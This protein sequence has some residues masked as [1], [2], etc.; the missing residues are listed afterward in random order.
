MLEKLA[1]IE[2]RW[3]EV[4]QQLSEPSALADMK[5][6]AKLNK[7]YKDLKVI[8]EEYYKY[9]NLLENITST[10]K[11]LATEKDQDFLEMAKAELVELEPKV[12]EMEEHIKNLLIPKDPE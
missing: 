1:A 3:K 4:E 10:K 2:T 5:L 11:V 8:V 7:E 12:A 6:F 9:R